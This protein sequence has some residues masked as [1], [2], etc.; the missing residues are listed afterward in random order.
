M[1]KHYFEG[2]EY[3]AVGPIIGLAIFFVFFVVLIYL[4]VKADSGFISKMANMPLDDDTE[5]KE[6]SSTSTQT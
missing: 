1:F 5:S 6:K 4:V 2:I 3:I